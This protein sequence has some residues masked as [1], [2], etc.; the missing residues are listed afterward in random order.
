MKRFVPLVLV[1]LWAPSVLSQESYNVGPASAPQVTTL[2]TV[3]A[4]LNGET[5]VRLGLPRTCT[6]AQ[7][8]ADSDCAAAGGASC[9]AAQARAAGCRLWI[10]STL[11]G[12]EEFVTF[13]I[14][15]PR[16][17]ELVAT[18]NAAAKFDFCTAWTANTGGHS[19]CRTAISAPSGSD[20]CVP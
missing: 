2:T 16:F 1:A 8:C 12:R 10:P 13:G 7:A 6:Q 17:N 3:I 18:Q 19:T 20:P 9:S 15:L 4:F 5:C 14:A 11:A